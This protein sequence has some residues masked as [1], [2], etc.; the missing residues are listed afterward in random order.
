MS[1]FC[2]SKKNRLN[3]TGPKYL[4]QAAE[5]N[6]SPAQVNLAAC[7]IS[8]EGTAINFNKGLALLKKAAAQ[9]DPNASTLA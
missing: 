6:L 2:E 9:G 8:G 5:S 1:I 7:Y 4:E 3:G